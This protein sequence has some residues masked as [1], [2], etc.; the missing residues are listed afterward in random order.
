MRADFQIAGVHLWQWHRP[1]QVDLGSICVDPAGVQR[2]PCSK[3]RT[4]PPNG[5][6]AWCSA[7]SVLLQAHCLSS[8]TG[9]LACLEPPAGVAIASGC[10]CGMH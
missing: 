9:A 4:K 2:A 7:L 3:L 8:A 10:C 1:L 6:Q 5:L